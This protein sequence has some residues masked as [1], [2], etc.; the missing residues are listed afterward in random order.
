AA[1]PEF[2]CLW[3]EPPA[4]PMRRERHLAP[5]VFFL[6]SLEAGVERGAVREDRALRGGPCGELARVRP[7]MEIRLALLARHARDRSLGD[8]LPLQREP[9]KQQRRAR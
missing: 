9:R 7:R 1:L 2:D 4:T 6:N 8:H 5:R 3:R